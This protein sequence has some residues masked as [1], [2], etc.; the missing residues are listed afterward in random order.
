M[1]N[2][3]DVINAPELATGEAFVPKPAK[4]EVFFTDAERLASLIQVHQGLLGDEAGP[5][6]PSL[7]LVETVGAAVDI[8]GAINLEL[9]KERQD[10]EYRRPAIL[11]LE[12]NDSQMQAVRFARHLT[13]RRPE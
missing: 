7:K 4:V 12:L 5:T 3:R 10:P 6:S 11:H 1:E 13:R 8:L 2:Y 9:E